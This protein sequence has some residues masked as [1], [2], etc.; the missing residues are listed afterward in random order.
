MRWAASPM[1][2]ALLRGLPVRL[3]GAHVAAMLWVYR[4][5]AYAIREYGV[6]SGTD[7]G[8]ALRL[9]KCVDFP[10]YWLGEDIMMSAFMHSDLPIIKSV[11]IGLGITLENWLL[12]GLW[13]LLF[14]FG[15]LQWLI[16]G[17]GIRYIR[18]LRGVKSI[19]AQKGG[20]AVGRP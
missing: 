8:R 9:A 1:K 15:T 11:I 20:G 4:E 17:I 3:A 14:V 7:A 16:I 2:L 6:V 5:L 18:S 19:A 13:P 12:R 10:V